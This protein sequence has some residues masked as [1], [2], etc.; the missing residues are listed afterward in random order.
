M[1][2]ATLGFVTE[3]GVMA[4]ATEAPT[5]TLRRSEAA[6][7]LGVHPNTVL[8]WAQKGMLEVIDLPN[9]RR[10]TDESVRQLRDRIY[11]SSE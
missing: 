11:G 5:A 6:E 4:I 10:Y 3:G 8:S 2:P 1:S 7:L 9:E